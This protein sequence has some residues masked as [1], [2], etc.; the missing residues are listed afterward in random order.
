MPEQEIQSPITWKGSKAGSDQPKSPGAFS[1][2]SRGPGRTDSVPPQ[3]SH[4]GA[5]RHS[6]PPLPGSTTTVVGPD[7]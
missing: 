6:E 2:S 7:D 4:G 5:S 1:T 3:A